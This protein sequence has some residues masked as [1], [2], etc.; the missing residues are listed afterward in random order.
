MSGVS[1]V[2]YLSFVIFDVPVDAVPSNLG[3]HLRADKANEAANGLAV[4]RSLQQPEHA[5]IDGRADQGHVLPLPL[6]DGRIIV[7]HQI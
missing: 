1:S 4:A 5:S 7:C 2:K 6:G 3:L